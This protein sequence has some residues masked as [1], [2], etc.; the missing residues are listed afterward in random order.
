LVPV[1]VSVFD[2]AG[3]EMFHTFKLSVQ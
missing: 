3:Q 2:K 1:I